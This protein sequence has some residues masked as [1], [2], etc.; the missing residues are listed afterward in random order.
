ML[1]RAY[2]FQT[3]CI[4]VSD[5]LVHLILRHI[6]LHGSVSAADYNVYVG[7]ST[8][9][10]HQITVADAIYSAVLCQEGVCIACCVCIT[11]CPCAA[12]SQNIQALE[13]LRIIL[14]VAVQS[15]QTVQSIV[16]I[17]TV[18]GGAHALDPVV[19]VGYFLLV[20]VNG[21]LAVC[22]LGLQNFLQFSRSLGSNCV[23][24][25]CSSFIILAVDVIVQI[26]TSAIA[27]QGVACAVFISEQICSTDL[28]VIAQT[29]QIQVHG[30]RTLY[31]ETA[32]VQRSHIGYCVCAQ[33]L[34]N[35]LCQPCVCLI[36]NQCTAF[37]QLEVY[38][39][40]I[41]CDSCEYAG[42]DVACNGSCQL[43]VRTISE[44]V[45]VAVQ[46]V[47]CNGCINLCGATNVRC[48]ILEQSVEVQTPFRFLLRIIL[49]IR[50]NVCEALDG[51]IGICSICCQS[52]HC[53]SRKHTL[54]ENQ[55]GAEHG[56]HT[57][58]EECLFHLFTSLPLFNIFHCSVHVLHSTVC[59]HS[60]RR[61]TYS[62][63][64]HSIQERFIRR[65]Y[66]KNAVKSI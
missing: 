50:I 42:L 6:S 54:C 26:L 1:Y 19:L 3:L 28:V 20:A 47:L 56:R 13:C 60:R 48:I 36:S 64:S 4:V 63:Y 51:D 46:Q 16:Y 2:N 15:V 32:E 38:L 41:C 44:E 65:F 7:Q 35:L 53:R 27:E 18:S 39:I 5:Q 9:V 12:C 57:S 23:L 17:R 8:K 58:L 52:S 66:H 45:C 61:L 31:T 62:T 49:N 55:A 37:S 25:D 14:A 33:S 29:G 40:G 43:I 59:P 34:F 30:N 24:Y 22:Q 11:S 21:L 10:A